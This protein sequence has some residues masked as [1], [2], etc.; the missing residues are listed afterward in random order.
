MCPADRKTNL[1]RAL[2]LGRLANSGDGVPSNT[3]FTLIE[4]LVVIAIIAILAALLLPALASAK[5]RAKR[6]QCVSN[7]KQWG[8]AFH[9]YGGDN[10]DSMPMGWYDFNGM[11]MT[12]LQP[13]IPGASIGGK[14]CYCPTAM[15]PR[16]SLPSFFGTSGTTFLAWGVMGSNGY[17]VIAPWGQP[18]MAGSYGVNGWMANPSEA[19]LMASGATATGS[20]YWRKLTMA[21]RFANAPLF[22]D[23]VWQGANPSPNDSFD[24]PPQHLGDCAVDAAIGSF[25]TVRHNGRKPSNM[26]FIDGSVSPVGMKQL[27][28]LPWSQTFDPTTETFPWPLW[29]NSYN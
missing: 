21:G 7:L 12:A 25:C 22:A 10:A 5:A 13:L 1:V 23:C 24:L 16:S 29:M 15:V 8:V 14:I 28:Q 17:P 11:W 19:G 20:G 9:I 2:D 4:L 26:A 27:W 18:G 6:I 3:G